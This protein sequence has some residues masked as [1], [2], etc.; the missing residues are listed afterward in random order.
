MG[1]DESHDPH[2]GGCEIAQEDYKE[3]EKVVDD[4]SVLV[5]RLA[6]R[7]KKTDPNNKLHIQAVDYLARNNLT[8]SLLRQKELQGGMM[9]EFNKQDE[10]IIQQTIDH[11]RHG[12]Y[13][14]VTYLEDGLQSIL[15][16]MKELQSEHEEPISGTDQLRLFE[17][18]SLAN[19]CI[20][21]QGGK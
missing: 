20:D 16:K 13:I 14:D 9:I 3:L 5:R 8:G 12:T 1:P 4:L 7:L 17:S 19:D 11:L 18:L 6:H 15:T 21:T 2:C 10:A